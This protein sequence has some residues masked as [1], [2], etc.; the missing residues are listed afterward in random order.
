MKKEKENSLNCEKF[1][2]QL[3][4]DGSRTTGAGRDRAL[5]ELQKSETVL[6]SRDA[7]T[8]PPTPGS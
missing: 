5:E 2:L 8:P 3:M 4:D 7:A 6:G 1:R